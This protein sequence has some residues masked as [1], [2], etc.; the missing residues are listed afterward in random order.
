[1]PHAQIRTKPIRDGG[2]SVLSGKDKIMGLPKS[3]AKKSAA[4]ETKSC[5][6]VLDGPECIQGQPGSKRRRAAS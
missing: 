5:K 3:R 6:S 1:M 4:T 2:V